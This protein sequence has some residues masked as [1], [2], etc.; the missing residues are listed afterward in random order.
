MPPEW[1]YFDTSALVKRYIS[2]PGSLQ[3][4]ALFRRHAFL[5]SAIVNP[6]LLSA[7]SRRRRLG[8]LSDAHFETLLGR[9]QS[10]KPRWELIEVSWAVLDSAER[11]IQGT[12]AIRTLD[13]IHV[14]SLITFKNTAGGEI[15]FV[16]ADARQRDTARQI[17][18]NV[19][20]IG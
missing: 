4:R 13:A 1:A 18:L 5:S 19:I 9:M 10:D 16:T 6:E 11:L 7:F 8:E 17:G 3:V 2:E 20:W 15:P 14:A 12:V